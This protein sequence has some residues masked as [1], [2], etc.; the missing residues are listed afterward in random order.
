[1]T[2]PV[3]VS[4]S[5]VLY[6]GRPAH[7]LKRGEKYEIELAD[8]RTLRVRAKDITLLHPG[9]LEGLEKLEVISGEPETAW[10]LLQDRETSL[11]ELAELAYGVYDPH[12]AWTTWLLVQ[13]GLYFQGTPE[14]IQARSAA[15]VAE[16][17]AAREAKA[18]EEMAWTA[19][20]KRAYQSQVLPE[21]ER[22]F[23]EVAALA[24][25]QQ[26][27]SRL[28]HE[29]DRAETPENAHSLLLKLGFWD[30]T[31]NPYP[32]RLG[33][34]DEPPALSPPMLPEEERR[35]LTH[36]PAFAIDDEGNQ[37]PDDAI[38]IDGERIWVHV[39]DVASIAPPDSPIDLEARSRGATLYL[40]EGTVPI[41]PVL[42]IERLGLGLHDVSPALSFGLTLNSGGQVQLA[43]IVPSWVRVTRLTYEEVEG[44]LEEDPFRRM[45]RL[46]QSY[47][48]A[49]LSHG[50]LEIVLPEVKVEVEDGRV[51]IRPL[52]S[53]RSRDLV[54]EAMLMTGEATARLALEQ[55][56][57]IP[58]TTQDPPDVYDLDDRNGLARMYAL[59]K[60]FQPSQQSTMPLSHAGL[61]IPYYAQTTSPLR[62]YLDLVVHQQLRAY[63]RG[64]PL[65]REH[66]VLERIGAAMAVNSSVRQAERLS[67]RHWTLVYLMQHPDWQGEGVL[68]EK[69]GRRTTLLIPDLDLETRMQLPGDWPLNSTVPLVLRGVNLPELDAHFGVAEQV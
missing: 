4:G 10:E 1:M 24:L 63:L 13:D 29:L 45:Y 15:E 43:E 11:A 56:I 36:L 54:R 33:L 30:A 66:Q 44:R 17:Q 51:S 31:V 19:F 60:T 64:Q 37:D 61:G 42:A 50:A 26:D 38:S 59:R 69:Y 23:K 47:E 35:D 18:A 53:L 32:R 12:S 22:Y 9:P 55:N 27:N 46:A 20:V 57:P 16:E 21:D 28:L 39:A 49:R 34:P 8:G 65:L 3:P 58:Y 6:K 68:V 7:V 48:E 40:P 2:P 5:L 67:C 14:S 52:P 25:G 62:R 41:L